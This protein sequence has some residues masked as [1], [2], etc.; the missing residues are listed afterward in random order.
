MRRAKVRTIFVAA[1]LLLAGAYADAKTKVKLG[2]NELPM[3]VMGG[4]LLVVQGSIGDRH[5]LKFLLDT[6][7]TT[8]VIDRKLADRLGLATD[9]SQMVNFD[10]TVRVQWCI[11]PEPVYGPER[12]INTKVVVA[13]LRYLRMSGA[14]VDGVIGW[15]LLRRRNFQL[16]FANK[17]VALS[18]AMQPSQISVWLPLRPLRE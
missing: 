18:T 3:N 12:A 10:K 6:G 5:G 13:D 1:F 16:D 17:R 15:D 4:Y 11:L 7:V 8:S 14:P 9:S 2:A